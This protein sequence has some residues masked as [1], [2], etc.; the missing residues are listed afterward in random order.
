ML[1]PAIL[2]A[3]LLSSVPASA[4]T[5]LEIALANRAATF[6][7]DFLSAASSNAV[8]VANPVA[9]SHS[10][11]LRTAGFAD[12]GF[13]WAEVK[14]VMESGVGVPPKG[15]ARQ[16]FRAY[17]EYNFFS[18]NIHIHENAAPILTSPDGISGKANENTRIKGV[19]G[20][21]KEAIGIKPDPLS[22]AAGADGP[23]MGEIFVPISLG[24]D[25]GP[26]TG[27]SF[28][29]SV[30]SEGG[31]WLVAQ[32][33][34]KGN[35]KATL[36]LP[37]LAAVDP[38]LAALVVADFEDRILA[39]KG[40]SV[41]FTLG[42]GLLPTGDSGVA[43]IPLLVPL[44]TP[45]WYETELLTYNSG[46]IPEPDIW[47]LMIAGFGLTGLCLRRRKAARRVDCAA[48]PAH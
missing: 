17:A 7:W 3:L 32:G 18:D 45:F 10:Q 44:D 46:A 48:E 41:S 22:A 42:D 26:R 9:V 21:L 43:G 31:S 47:M 14:G 12:D 37:T 25:L 33:S 11:G 27:F 8:A 23:A 36:L 29:V 19:L 2:T 1:K 30:V 6:V 5:T 34:G 40:G 16:P 28:S 38:E 13:F 15:D 4:F 39:G 20:V 35:G 24:S